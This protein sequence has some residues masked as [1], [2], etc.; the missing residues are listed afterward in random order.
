MKRL[1]LLVFIIVASSTLFAQEEDFL[2]FQ[3]A[4]SFKSKVNSY[5]N[6]GSNYSEN[7]EVHVWGSIEKRGT[8]RI[9]KTTSLVELF[10][11]SG[12]LTQ[13]AEIEDLRIVRKDTLNPGMSKIIIVNYD[14][15]FNE[16]R[17]KDAGSVDVSLQDGDIII[18]PTSRTWWTDIRFVTTI[19]SFV[20]AITSLVIVIYRSK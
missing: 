10:S 2:N 9:P 12:G 3:D 15:I 4:Y 20:S 7:I 14:D 17:M 1:F 8:Y 13:E 6:L 5:Y 19:I 11:F 16:E 18:V